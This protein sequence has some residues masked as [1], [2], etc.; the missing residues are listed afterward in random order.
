[1]SQLALAV[2]EV[3]VIDPGA[4]AE[5]LGLTRMPSGTW[6]IPELLEPAWN[7][8]TPPITRPS[9]TGTVSWPAI[10]APPLLP[11]MRRRHAGRRPSCT[12]STSMSVPL[13]EA[14]GIR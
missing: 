9:A 2:A 11:C 10:R 6:L 5:G 1:M 13:A 12:Q 8:T 3:V 14:Y 7:A 4:L